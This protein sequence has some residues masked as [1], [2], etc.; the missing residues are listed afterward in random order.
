MR[1]LLKRAGLMRHGADMDNGRLKRE[2]E[3]WPVKENKKT[4]KNT[5]DN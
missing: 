5:K 1:R 2:A 4:P 3:E